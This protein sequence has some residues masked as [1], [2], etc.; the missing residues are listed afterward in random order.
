[1]IKLLFVTLAIVISAQT[2]FAG[3]AADVVPTPR[4]P[5]DLA[6]AYVATQPAPPNPVQMT[7]TLKVGHTIPENLLLL[8]I[9][10]SP[11]YAFVFVNQIRLIIDA[12]TRVVI[13][14]VD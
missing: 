12:R 6:V 14:V 7:E 2:V 13:Q 1:M 3:T 11:D 10:D 9:P 5:T 8:P 4:P